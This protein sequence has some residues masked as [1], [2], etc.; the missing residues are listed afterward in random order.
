MDKTIE[1]ARLKAEIVYLKEC[2]DSQ[3]AVF[4]LDLATAKESHLSADA[5]NE[6]WR[7]GF[8]AGVVKRD[9]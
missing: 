6:A 9:S 3:A 8:K 7:E 2:L 5:I 4:A 1:V